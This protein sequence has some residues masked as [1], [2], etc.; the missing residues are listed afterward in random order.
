MGLVAATV[1]GPVAAVAEAWA[2]AAI[3]G[4]IKHGLNLLSAC[5]VDALASGQDDR[6]Y[7][8]GDVFAGVTE[9]IT[10]KPRS[11]GPEAGRSRTNSIVPAPSLAP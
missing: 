2:K 5:G 4:G 8:V 6:L 10:L 3:V 7:G 1:V 9:T 11:G